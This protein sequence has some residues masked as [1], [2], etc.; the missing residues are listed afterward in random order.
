LHVCP[1]APH[2]IRR[3]VVFE[4]GLLVGMNEQRVINQQTPD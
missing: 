2:G 1:Q 4:L 3:Q